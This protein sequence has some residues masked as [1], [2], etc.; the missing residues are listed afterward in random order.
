V[1]A[2]DTLL[3]PTLQARAPFAARQEENAEAD[4]AEDDGD[5]RRSPVREAP[6]IQEH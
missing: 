1:D 4:L 3:K 6:A 5:R 2:L